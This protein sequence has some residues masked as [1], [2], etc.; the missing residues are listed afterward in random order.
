M[1]KK[2]TL[3]MVEIVDEIQFSDLMTIQ[4]RYATYSDIEC[5]TEFIK[6]GRFPKF[7]NDFW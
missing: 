4:I 7:A 5:L 2:A 1:M 6:D 3:R